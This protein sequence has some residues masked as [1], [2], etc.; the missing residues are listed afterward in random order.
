MFLRAHAFHLCEWLPNLGR[1]QVSP[2]DLQSDDVTAG[3]FV[4]P[5]RHAYPMSRPQL[6]A[7]PVVQED[8][9]L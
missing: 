9:T 2:A 1:P 3:K 8:L 7:E 5:F 4:I 6:Q